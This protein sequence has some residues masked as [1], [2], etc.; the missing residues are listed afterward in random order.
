MGRFALKFLVVLAVVW[1]GWWYLATAGMQ[2]SVT[3]WLDERRAAGWEAEVREVARAGFPLRIGTQIN[4]L[5]LDDPATLAA[6]RIPQITLST[7]IYWPG[8]A[9]ARLPA[10]PITL[11]TARGVLTLTTGGA[12]AAMRLHPGT[13]LQLEALRGKASDITLDLVEGRV[14]SMAALTTTARQGENPGTYDIDFDATEFA[15]GSI[16]RESL[17]LPDAWPQAV[18][19]LVAD[20]TVTFERPWDRTALEGYR[21][22]PQAITVDRIEAVWA[23]V[24]IAMAADLTVSQSGILSGSLNLQAQNWQRMLDL[25]TTGGAISASSR[26]QIENVITLLSGLSGSSDSLDLDITIENGRMRMGFI[27]LGNAPVLILR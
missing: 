5:A 6:L 13:S 24:R 21:P 19:T 17:G 12:E 8:H 1:V 23:D 9:T 11:T 16:I 25:A 10:E 22:Q 14:L 27:P 2:G 20:M 18:E 3:T 7:P 4:D 15:P 26:P